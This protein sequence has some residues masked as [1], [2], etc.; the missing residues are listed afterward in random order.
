MRCFCNAKTFHI[1][2]NKNN[3]C[4]LDIN[5]WNFNQ[6]LSNEFISFEQPGPECETV[7]PCTVVK[8]LIIDTEMHLLTV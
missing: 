5:V 7:Y 3:L 8:I 1:F 4:I 6:M 2:F